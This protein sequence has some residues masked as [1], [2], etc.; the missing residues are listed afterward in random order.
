MK[1]L[2]VL[3]VSKLFFIR[4]NIRKPLKIIR[5]QNIMSREDPR[6]FSSNQGENVSPPIFALRVPPNG[7]L[8]FTSSPG[9]PTF[10]AN[11]NPGKSS[12]DGSGLR[13]MPL[14]TAA[15]LT[16]TNHNN[17]TS[18][19]PTNQSLGNMM[20]ST[21]ANHSHPSMLTQ[22]ANGPDYHSFFIPHNEREFLHTAAYQA[23][24]PNGYENRSIR[25]PLM[26]QGTNYQGDYDSRSIGHGAHVGQGINYYS[27]ARADKWTDCWPISQAN[28]TSGSAAN[29]AP[30]SPN[31]EIPLTPPNSPILPNFH[32]A[33]ASPISMPAP[34]EHPHV[35]TPSELIT[36]SASQFTPQTAAQ[37]SDSASSKA[38]HEVSRST[39]RSVLTKNGAS[40]EMVVAM[41]DVESCN[42]GIGPVRAIG[43]VIASYNFMQYDVLQRMQWI[44]HRAPNEYDN[45]GYR[46]W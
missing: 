5:P 39:P 36:P 23:Q 37:Y 26:G 6:F 1:S 38:G 14:I 28:V 13:Q 21:A 30:R 7:P 18:F 10:Y 27:D 16:S 42:P 41:I 8:S 12:S 17:M 3:K 45:D 15:D 24:W 11:D 20:S 35:S 2:F 34:T 29:A 4:E 40:A 33:Y 31:A 22:F 46:F 9:V 32:T 19:T 43:I 44:I 25:H